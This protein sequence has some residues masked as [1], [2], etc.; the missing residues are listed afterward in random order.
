M[1]I[2]HGNLV[3]AKAMLKNPGNTIAVTHMIVFHISSLL[4]S[5]LVIG[6]FPGGLVVES[7]V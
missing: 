6:R 1:R 2:G 3:D 7:G 5:V 4:F